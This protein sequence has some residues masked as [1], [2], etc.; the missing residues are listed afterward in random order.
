M[1]GGSLKVEDTSDVEIRE[2]PVPFEPLAALSSELRQDVLFVE[3]THGNISKE[4]HRADSV[5]V[6]FSVPGEPEA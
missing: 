6:Y 3:G 4:G 1:A 5:P 2:F